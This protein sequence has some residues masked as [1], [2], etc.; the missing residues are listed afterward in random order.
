VRDDEPDLDLAI[1]RNPRS[2]L[3]HRPVKRSLA[4]RLLCATIS[5]MPRRAVSSTCDETK[6]FLREAR[7]G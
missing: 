7:D 1:V 4:L 2:R 5:L 3:F 6:K